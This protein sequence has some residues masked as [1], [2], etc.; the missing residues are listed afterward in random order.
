MNVYKT[1]SAFRKA[2]EERL[3]Q[4]A[5]LEGIDIGRV[6]RQLAFDRL[7]ARLFHSGDMPWALK[8]G[9][10]LELQFKAA[11]STVDIDLTLFRA[12]VLPEGIDVNQAI[13]ELL[14]QSAN[15][16]MADWLDFLIG[17]AQVDTRGAIRRR[18]LSHRG[19]HG[20][21]HFA[22]FHLDVG[23]GDV[24]IQPLTSIATHDW[25]SFAGISASHVQAIA[26][27]QQFAEKVH[28]YTLPRTTPNSRVKDLVDM[29]LLVYNQELDEEQSVLALKLTFARR[30][31]HPLPTTLNAPPDSWHR[32]FES[33]ATECG[34]QMNCESAHT[35]V[36][37]F[38]AK[39][40]AKL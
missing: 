37:A 29:A 34:I 31:T 39:L 38:F 40:T 3:R 36:N 4:K 30:K 16:P 23:I 5:M 25:L 9:Y 6:R 27:E 1:P 8:G 26:K 11:R 28:A 12:V 35:C 24:A 2:I 22:R 13:R 15:I 20:Q 10:A 19:T 17:V 18:A 32:P 33:L 21:S 14:Q 7:L